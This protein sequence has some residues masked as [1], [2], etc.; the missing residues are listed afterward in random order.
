MSTDLEELK[1]GDSDTL[2][3]IY[4]TYR[5]ECLAFMNQRYQM[6]GETALDVYQDVILA[7]HRNV[8]AGKLTELSSSLKT[9]LFAIAKN[10]CLKKMEQRNTLYASSYPELLEG[11]IEENDYDYDTDQRLKQLMQQYA[12]MG[13]PC[14]SVLNLYYFKRFSMR[15]IAEQLKYQSADVA[16]TQK[17]R[18]IKMLRNL[19]KKD[20]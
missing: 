6:E 3:R 11:L 7:L 1:Q 18:C 13:E 10:L 2:K 16:K 14:K 12:E 20:A 8:L 19:L 4:L 17:S 9:Y 5:E 15:Q